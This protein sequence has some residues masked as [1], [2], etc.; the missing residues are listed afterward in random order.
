MTH[1]EM[2]QE[3]KKDYDKLIS[4]TILRLG[5][6]YD[7]ERN[8]L[9]IDKKRAYT[10]VYTVKTAT[11]NRWI[12][13]L[14]RAPSKEIYTGTESLTLCCVAYYYDDEGLKA[15]QWADNVGVVQAYNGHFF[16]RYNERLN[17]GLSSPF[18]IVKHYFGHNRYA[19]QKPIVKQGRCYI[20]GFSKEGLLLGEFYFEHSWITWR[21]F[22]SRDLIRPGQ[23]KTEKQLIADLQKEIEEE[24][25]NE[26]VQ[27]ENRYKLDKFNVLTGHYSPD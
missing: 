4:T 2:I 3:I 27:A 7:R 8:K 9:R 25:K 1:K 11:K 10:K 26:N 23:D 12:I 21:T 15:F 6:E 17:L 18:E 16:T 13:V 14:G 5:K 24:I 19:Y 22:V 20:I